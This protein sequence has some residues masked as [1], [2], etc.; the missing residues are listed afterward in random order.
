MGNK[1]ERKVKDARFLCGRCSK[2]MTWLSA[3]IKGGNAHYQYLCGNCNMHWS[4][5]GYQ[6]SKR[7][8]FK[9]MTA[10]GRV[11]NNPSLVKF[12]E[13]LAQSGRAADC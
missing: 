13:R 2:E 11:M 3:K 10:Y 8:R 1:K 4:I 6:S 5:I 12:M 7:D 9:M